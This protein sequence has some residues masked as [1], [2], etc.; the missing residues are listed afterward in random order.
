MICSVVIVVKAFIKSFYL[1]GTLAETVAQLH[2]GC[3]E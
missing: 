2:N 1:K 3:A